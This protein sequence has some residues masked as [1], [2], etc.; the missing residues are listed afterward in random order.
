MN[1]SKN[2]NRAV[3]IIR[4]IARSWSILSIAFLLLMFI[5][6]T[7][8]TSGESN[9]ITFRDMVGLIFFPFGLCIGLI[10][11][12]K[13]EELG[14]MIAIGSTIGFHV[15]MLISSGSLDI[16]PFI[17][18]TAA[19]GLLFL[20]CWLLSRGQLETKETN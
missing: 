6:E 14:G 2:K 4:W 5:G 10:I 15:T 1:N 8:F 18:G 3:T 7:F 9:P 20:I 12:W 13:W 16:N 19:P 11:A 17:E